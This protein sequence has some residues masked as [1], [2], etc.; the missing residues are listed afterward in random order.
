MAADGNIMDS[1]LMV[2]LAMSQVPTLFLIY[3][4]LLAVNK[5][6]HFLPPKSIQAMFQGPKQSIH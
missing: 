3:L 1:L 6:T 5:N 2:A 4:F